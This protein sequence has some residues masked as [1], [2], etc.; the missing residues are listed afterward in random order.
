VIP[1]GDEPRLTSQSIRSFVLRQGRMSPAQT[2]AYEAGMPRFGVPFAQTSFDAV[3]AFGRAAPL[4]VEIGFGMGET[5]ARIAHE[6]PQTNFLGIEVHEPGVGALLKRIEELQL[7]NLRVIRHDAVEV[8]THMFTP[9]SI[10]GVHLFFPDPWPKAR[11]HKRRIVQQGFAALIASRLKPGG[12]WHC[13][14]DWE[15]Y[16]EHMLEVLSTEPMLRNSAGTGYAPRPATR[17]LT[18]FENRGLK[19][20]H[21][22]F[23]LVFNK[24]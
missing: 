21:G 7:S 17:P 11:H 22:V 4:T 13:A 23:D 10:D 9:N 8:I 6:S 19:L 24:I 16:A 18:K 20:G 1:S 14:T 5:T 12:Y 3:E 2:R 15:P